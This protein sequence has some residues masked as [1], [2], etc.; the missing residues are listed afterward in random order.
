MYQ[1]EQYV[2]L[3]DVDELVRDVQLKEYQ[4]QIYSLVAKNIGERK[5]N[6]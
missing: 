1:F 4:Q 3:I 6:V 5:Q 2:H